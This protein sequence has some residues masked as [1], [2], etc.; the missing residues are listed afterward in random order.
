MIEIE[1]CSKCLQLAMTL[2]GLLV[3]IMYGSQPLPVRGKNIILTHI[4]AALD[5]VIAPVAMTAS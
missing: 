5:G 2:H 4:L 1:I 3:Q